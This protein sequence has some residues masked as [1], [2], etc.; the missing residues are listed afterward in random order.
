IR[1]YMAVREAALCGRHLSPSVS[2]TYAARSSRPSSALASTRSLT[3]Q[4]SP[5]GSELTIDGSPTTASLTSTISPDTGAYSSPTD[6]VDSI[7]PHTSPPVT[8]DPAAGRSTYTTSPS[9][10]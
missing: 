3:S 4:P 5:N 1:S 8:D 2:A 10:S 6:F 7:S 9:L